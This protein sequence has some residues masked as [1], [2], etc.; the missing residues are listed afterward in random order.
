MT[1]LKKQIIIIAAIVLVLALLGLTYWLLTKDGGETPA[2]ENVEKGAFGETMKNGRPFIVDEVESEN[3]NSIKVHNTL[4]EYSLI[5]KKS[6]AYK[7][8]GVD[9]YEINQSMLSQLRVNTLHL[10]ALKYVET[11][12]MDNLE[13]YGINK[14]NPEEWFEVTYNNEKDSYKIIIGD[15]TPDGSGYYVMLEGRDALYVIDT[16]IENCV[17]QPRI[18][19]ITPKL[20]DEV[21]AT[22]A[23]TLKDFTFNK[24]G[25]KH[26]MIEKAS[27]DKTYGNNAS[28]RLTYPAYNYATNLVNFESLLTTLTTLGS[29]E[30]TSLLQ[31]MYYGDAI[32][33]E[34]LQTLGF[35]DADGNDISDYSFNY[36]Y[37]AF[38]EY[39]YVM[40]DSETQSYTVYSLKENIIVRAPAELFE[41][42]EWDMLLWVS[43]EIYM[44]DIEDIASLEFE[45]GTNKVK[46]S[47]A[48]TGETLTASCNNIPVDTDKFK[49]L[50]KSIMYVLAVAY[51]ENGEYG[52][53]QL[54]LVVTTEKG[55]VLDYRFYAHTAINSYYT[56][57]GFGEFYVSAEKVQALREMAFGF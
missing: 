6:G 28:H 19:Y 52:A 27:G 43:S 50:Y 32:T 5:H 38:T 49:E 15:K 30:T 14:S 31:T 20:V 4:D 45:Y 51:A 18:S 41:F 1:K 34:L 3:F 22:Q 44:L 12:E 39:V 29:D 57:N 9:G 33:P 24:S 23:Y 36:S 8:E 21:E 25:E 40:K 16:G 11:A 2:E 10:L 48:G 42:F 47:I 7:L 26:I 37:P 35:F 54:R 13:Q 55:E 53:Q 46:F 56:L 17:L